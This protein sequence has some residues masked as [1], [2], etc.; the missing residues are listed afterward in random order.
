MGLVHA[1]GNG[2]GQVLRT[3]TEATREA[4]QKAYIRLYRIF[5]DGLDLATARATSKACAEVLIPA[6][7]SHHVMPAR[8]LVLGG[9]DLTVLVRADLA[10][11]FTRSFLYHFETQSRD[12][13]SHLREDMQAQGLHAA[14]IAQIPES[15]SACAGI[16]YMKAS[17]PF[18]QS[19]A[20][21]EDLCNRAKQQSRAQAHGDGCIPSSLAFHRLQGSVFNSA[22]QLFQRELLAQSFS[23]SGTPLALGLPAY[24]LH[25]SNHLPALG[26]LAALA[27]CFGPEKLSDGRL[28]NLATLLHAD[29]A[30]A[31]KNYA[32]WREL[33]RKSPPTATAL[34]H[35]DTALEELL[36]S[37]NDSLPTDKDCQ[38]SPLADLLNYLSIHCPNV[39]DTAHA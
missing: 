26:A 31:R 38:S 2:L 4:E 37:R 36:G 27:H 33:A 1:D 13:L 39:E 21:A 28:R 10:L 34:H 15:L 23:G 12:F 3:L 11:P 32:R 24:G 5:S 8:P 16:I 14:N 9:D 22:E 29:E 25:S 30:L 35:F 19:Y 20:L 17:Q 6:I 18:A 7:N